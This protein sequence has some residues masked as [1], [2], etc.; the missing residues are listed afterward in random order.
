MGAAV[1]LPLQEGTAEKATVRGGIV[2][3]ST[4]TEDFVEESDTVDKRIVGQGTDDE[5]TAAEGTKNEES[6]EPEEDTPSKVQRYLREIRENRR[7]TL[8]FIIQME[9]QRQMLISENAEFVEMFLEE[10]GIS[11]ADDDEASSDASLSESSDDDDTASVMS[12]TSTK[13]DASDNGDAAFE[14]NDA[15]ADDQQ[16]DM[17]SSAA[18]ENESDVD[19]GSENE[20]DAEVASIQADIDDTAEA[21]DSLRNEILSAMSEIHAPSVQATKSHIV[22]QSERTHKRHKTHIGIYCEICATPEPVKH[23][24][25]VLA[26]TYDAKRRDNAKPRSK[27]STYP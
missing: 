10:Q 5:Q 9:K 13:N 6:D 18:D 21:I 20:T 4:A 16:E 8:R 26:L 22:Q 3:K 25:H 24:S 2:G 15:E 12:A 19:S 17:S 1:G 11:I 14:N 7:E 23:P 27:I